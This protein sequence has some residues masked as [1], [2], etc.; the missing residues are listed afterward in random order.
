MFSMRIK[1]FFASLIAGL[2]LIGWQG[3]DSQ[4]KGRA[5][6]FIMAM[7]SK[8]PAKI[9]AMI[10]DNFAPA[11]FEKRKLEAWAEQSVQISQDLAPIT[12]E[13]TLLEKPSAIVYLVK[14]SAGEKLGLRIDCETEAPFKIIG[15]RLDQNAD[16]LLEI[17]KPVDFSSYTTLSDLAKRIHENANAPA[18]GIATWKDGKLEVGVDGF[19]KA[20]SPELATAE[21]RWLVGSIGKS[22]T[23]TLLG[24]LIEE[25]KLRWDSTLG[26]LLKDIPMKDA[27]RAVTLEQV[28]QHKGGIPQDMGFTG[29]TVD[30]I[31]GTLTDPVAI[32]ASYAKDILNR[33]PIG[34]PGERF[35]YSNAGYALLGHIAERIAKKPFAGLLKERVFDPI[36]MTTAIC[37]MPGADGMP[38]G[39]G[40]PHGHFPAKEGPRPGKLGGALTHMAAP[41]GGGIACS[42]SDLAKYAAWHMRG[43]N[44]DSVPGLKVATIK[45]L[46]TPLSL[47]AGTERY[48]AGW[49][50][51]ASVGIE[52]HGHNGSDGTFIA[53]MAFFPK[54]NL[55]IVGITNMGGEGS[56]SPG[57]NAISTIL[58]RIQKG[59]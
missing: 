8:D 14:V 13:K 50:V 11:M 9:K 21:D 17:K 35:R 37:G 18:M 2:C 31:A 40:Q 25:G 5:D 51:D 29:A 36:G 1:V 32:R 27:Y 44:G 33:D 24:T 58:K 39:K 46:H 12:V 55:V 45:R 6:H 49:S 26:E 10:Q 57:E 4:A 54:L 7:N 34:K 41:A 48:A 20:G 22:M 47:G 30:R 38:S 43:W 15:I 42:V 16:S 59:G 23:S 28:M 56:P 53:E 52:K 19:R 3:L